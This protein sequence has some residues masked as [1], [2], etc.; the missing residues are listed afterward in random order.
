MSSYTHLDIKSIRERVNK[1]RRL[2]NGEYCFYG[3]EFIGTTINPNERLE[4]YYLI[5]SL[6]NEIEPYLD[7]IKHDIKKRSSLLLNFE[8]NALEFL[9]EVYENEAKY[10]LDFK[11]DYNI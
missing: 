9:I 8:L 1:A 10:I 5:E 11:R 6:Y 2:I 7:E 4:G 3:R